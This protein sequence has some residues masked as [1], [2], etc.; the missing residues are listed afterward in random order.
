MRD[1]LH[2]GQLTPVA[3]VVQPFS[4]SRTFQAFPVSCPPGH[5]VSPPNGHLVEIIPHK[6]NDPQKQLRDSPRLLPRH[7]TTFANA[8]PK[9]AEKSI[10]TT[11]YYD[12]A[13]VR[14][15]SSIRLLSGPMFVDR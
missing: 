1:V 7:H 8:P 11:S 6:R 4:L 9:G 15:T 5:R 12:F 14:L 2:R 10:C 3:P 13:G